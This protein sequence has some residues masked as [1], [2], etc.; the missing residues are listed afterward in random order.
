[1]VLD[2]DKSSLSYA[3]KKKRKSDNA[4]VPD[5]EITVIEYS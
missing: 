2:F 4:E 3:E 1:M 5:H